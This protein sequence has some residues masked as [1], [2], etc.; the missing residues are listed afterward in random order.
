M[1]IDQRGGCA[2]GVS[3]ETHGYLQEPPGLR[4]WTP[5]FCGYRSGVDL[6]KVAGTAPDSLRPC[7]VL[8]RIWIA[9]A[10]PGPAGPPFGVPA[11][12]VLD[13][14]LKLH[15][16]DTR[17]GDRQA[18]AIADVHEGMAHSPGPD[19]GL[20]HSVGSGRVQREES[21]HRRWF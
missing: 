4:K 16:G 8:Q 10:V 11:A 1:S 19:W 6:A 5:S 21:G 15:G 13:H 9:R 18:D 20:W 7:I 3:A 17:R 12:S 14:V 2:V